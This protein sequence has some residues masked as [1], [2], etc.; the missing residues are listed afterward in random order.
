MPTVFAIHGRARTH[1]FVSRIVATLP[2]AELVGRSDSAAEAVRVFDTLAPDAV[3]VDVRLP[4]GDGIDLALRLSTRR[5]GLCVVL[6]GPATDL[7]LRRALTAGI[8]AHLLETADVAQA[9]AAIHHCLAGRTS[10]PSRSLTDALRNGRTVNL[11]PRE[12]EV[13]ALI[14]DGLSPI[15]IA[16]RLHVS[17]S[18][19]RT[20]VARARAKTGVDCGELRGRNQRS[21][22][23]SPS[24]S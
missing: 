16:D 11:S 10:F 21:E 19:V 24:M 20:Y 18:T 17:E 1:L 4:D 13:N 6:L 14:R 23:E 22:F 2:R 15:E 7:L 8:S 3:T 12:R 9:T 5:P